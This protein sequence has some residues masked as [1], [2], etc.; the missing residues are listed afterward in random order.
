MKVIIFK[1][2]LIFSKIIFYFIFNIVAQ[3]YDTVCMK[4]LG[5]RYNSNWELNQ[6]LLTY[7]II[8]YFSFFIILCQNQKF[9]RLDI[10]KNFNKVT[11]S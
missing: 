10:K 5:L 3:L 6:L 8:R 11:I 9:K 7:K 1:C 2:F 4:F